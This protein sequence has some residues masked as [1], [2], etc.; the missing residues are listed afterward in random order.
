MDIDIIEEV[1]EQLIT[2]YG[3]WIAQESL[4]KPYGTCWVKRCQ[5]DIIAYKNK[6]KIFACKKHLDNSFTFSI[7]IPKIN[8]D[9]LNLIYSQYN[10]FFT[11]RELITIINELKKENVELKQR[12]QNYELNTLMT[13]FSLK[14][15]FK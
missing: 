8:L 6:G 14:N 2:S 4:N 15:K 3:T 5:K 13:N 12:L 10:C 11:R 9:Q 1:E 7:E